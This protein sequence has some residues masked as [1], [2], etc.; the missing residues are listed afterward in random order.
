M[1]GRTRIIEVRWPHYGAHV[2]S[3]RRRGKT[4]PY[5]SVSRGLP[6]LLHIFWD[7]VSS[8][9]RQPEHIRSLTKS[10]EL[11]KAERLRSGLDHCSPSSASNMT[12]NI[13]VEFDVGAV[14]PT[15]RYSIR[16]NW[17][18]LGCWTKGSSMKCRS[19][20]ARDQFIRQ[21]TAC[22]YFP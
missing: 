13:V 22:L 11:N 9:E 19:I 16:K 4:G 1:N 15:L 2:A 7:D 17:S 6:S 3:K 18:D 20:S 21:D 12:P 10:V 8:V 14:L 5:G